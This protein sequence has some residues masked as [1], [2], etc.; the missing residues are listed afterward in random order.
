MW[1]PQLLALLSL[2][3][4]DGLGGLTNDTPTTSNP[5]PPLTLSS[6]VGK[7]YVPAGPT[8]VTGNG[9][10]VVG[11]RSATI[12]V[13]SATQLLV[14]N[15]L[16]LNLQS[17]GKTFKSDDGSYKLVVNGNVEGFTTDQVLYMLASEELK[18]EGQWQTTAYVMGNTT[19]AADIPTSGTATYSGKMTVFNDAGVETTM[20]GPTLTVDLQRA[21]VNGTVPYGTNVATLTPTALDQGTFL[22]TMSSGGSTPVITGTIDGT[23]FGASG[24]EIAGTVGIQY[25]PGGTATESVVGY[26]GTTTP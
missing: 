17:D 25:N 6:A 11:D 24:K 21:T 3:A 8:M 19:P 26:Y 14:N 12:T 9:F 5:Y 15:S 20:E 16:T 1:K 4:C 22:T 2:A 13:I 7:T 18:V 10:D 23:M